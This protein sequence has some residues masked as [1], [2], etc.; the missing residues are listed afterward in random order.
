MTL[1][2][3]TAASL[4]AALERAGFSPIFSP[5]GLKFTTRPAPEF[6]PLLAVLHTGARAI[7]TNR[8]WLGCS[9]DSGWCQTIDPNQPIPSWVGLLAVQGDQRWDRIRISARLN[10]PILFMEQA[11]PKGKD[12]LPRTGARKRAAA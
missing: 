8:P 7:L 3:P 2:A 4:L 5:H 9:T 11:E 10:I 6:V 1:H 12:R